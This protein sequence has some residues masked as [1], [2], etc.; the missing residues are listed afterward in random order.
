MGG[1][2]FAHQFLHARQGMVEV[3]PY[4][5]LQ[6]RQTDIPGIFADDFFQIK[7]LAGRAQKKAQHGL[8]PQATQDFFTRQKVGAAAGGA[9]KKITLDKG[10]RRC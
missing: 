5:L 3:P 2:K 4:R 10:G 8:V 1:G 9:G 7:V 6:V